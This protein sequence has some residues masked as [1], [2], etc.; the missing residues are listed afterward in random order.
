MIQNLLQ[1]IQNSSFARKLLSGAFWS[2]FGVAGAKVIIL[3]AGILVANIIGKA[4]YG[5]LGIIRS[6]INT[7]VIFASMGLG[8]TATKYISEYRDNNPDKAGNIYL[9]SNVFATIFGALMLVVVLLLAP[10]IASVALKAPHLVTEIRM[11]GVLLFFSSLNGAQTGTLAGF[12]DFKSIAINTFIAGIIEGLF[13]CLGAYYFDVKG[14]ILGSGISFG[15][16]YVLNFLS[17][18]KHL[19]RFNITCFYS[20]LRV[21]DFSILIKF[22]IP[23]ALSSL[24]VVPLFW[25]IKTLLVKTE[26]FSVSADFDVADQWRSI[27]LF[28][29][30]ALSRIVLPMLSNI[31]GKKNQGAQYKK[32]LKINLLLNISL[33][34]VSALIIIL[35]SKY[36]IQLYGNEYT[37]TLPLIILAISTIFSSITTI[38]GQAIASKARMWT[39]F[40]F[41]LIWASIT[42]A[43]SYMF[44]NNGMGAQGLALAVLIGYVM[45]SL[46]QGLYIKLYILK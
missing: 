32:I 28:I 1:K 6:T 25:Y 3:I 23:A 2:L 26:G 42:L 46:G 24:L 10:Y 15:V 44:L 14:A 8:L 39:G 22:S 40:S 17:I 16:L 9:I 43:L 45:L 21:D 19:K 30:A 33:A 12:E 31:E 4:S 34:I 5:E 35:F 41:N 11:G 38:A 37:N 27:I 7:F 20:R 36:I 18:R 29:P 13:L